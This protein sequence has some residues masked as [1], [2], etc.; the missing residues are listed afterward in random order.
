LAL[1]CPKRSNLL[2]ASGSLEMSL[3][4]FIAFGLPPGHNAQR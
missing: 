1:D 2:M 4:R 3:N